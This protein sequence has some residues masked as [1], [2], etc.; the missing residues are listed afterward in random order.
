MADAHP[1]V[2]TAGSVRA[3]L[4]WPTKA[5]KAWAA[6]ARARIGSGYEKVDTGRAYL[7]TRLTDHT[8]RQSLV[9]ETELVAREGRA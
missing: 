7:W 5:V 3:V 6:R 9:E 4:T 1:P 2:R 8:E